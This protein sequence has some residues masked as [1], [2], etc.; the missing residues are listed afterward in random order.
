LAD[1]MAPVPGIGGA[2]QWLTPVLLDA[3]VGIMVGALVLAV[4]SGAR[5]FLRR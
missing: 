4:V 3:L 2:L 5:N 1:G